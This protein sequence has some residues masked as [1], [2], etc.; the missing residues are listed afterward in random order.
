MSVK[1][2]PHRAIGARRRSGDSFP[3]LAVVRHAP[4]LDE[5][6]RGLSRLTA[7][8]ASATSIDEL[9]AI[10]SADAT[11][12]CGY[13]RA[14]VLVESAGALRATHTG[15]ITVPAG[16]ALRRAIR[17]DPVPVRAGCAE[18]AALGRLA[19]VRGRSVLADAHGLEDPGFAGFAVEGLPG[20]RRALLVADRPVDPQTD[21]AVA[22]LATYARLLEHSVRCLTLQDRL[23]RIA[24]DLGA[25]AASCLVLA[26]ESHA[27]VARMGDIAPRA[28][29]D[30]F[31]ACMDGAPT[32][33]VGPAAPAARLTVRETHVAELLATGCTY[34]QIAETLHLSR[35]AVRLETASII[36]KLGV[37]NRVDAVARYRASSAG[38][39]PV[40]C[41]ARPGLPA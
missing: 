24:T 6:A 35:S 23:A 31:T 8:H 11:T 2:R 9:F 10:A 25:V 16:D 28:V 1:E 4:P 21:E 41:G 29:P 37:K 27:P 19:A 26:S 36:R 13:A 18:E 40:P 30:A 15:A 14:V 17:A 20:V 33:P 3:R 38:R 5:A 32:P 12:A 39:P 7:R 34:G 22:A